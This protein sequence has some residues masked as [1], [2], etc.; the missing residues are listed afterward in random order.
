MS[1]EVPEKFTF[2]KLIM[3]KL[4]PV[5]LWRNWHYHNPNILSCVPKK[6]LYPYLNCSLKYDVFGIIQKLGDQENSITPKKRWNGFYYKDR[7]IVG[8]EWNVFIACNLTWWIL[9]ALLPKAKNY[10]LFTSTLKIGPN[11]IT[12]G[13]R[14]NH[15]FLSCHAGFERFNGLPTL[16]LVTL[17]PFYAVLNRFI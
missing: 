14:R 11:F 13:G 8:T 10:Q 2:P 12:S 15:A 5:R 3:Q 4:V 17:P 16:C 1:W 7:K 9:N 6:N